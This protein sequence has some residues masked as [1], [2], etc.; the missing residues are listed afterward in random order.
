MTQ[1]ENERR[2]YRRVKTQVKVAI[3]KYDRNSKDV[4]DEEGTT[5][6]M[7]IG[8]LLVQHDKPLD[9][10]S[11]VI[12]SFGVPGVQEKLDFVGKV[13]RIEELSTGGYEVG[14]MF[15][16]VIFGDIKEFSRFVMTEMEKE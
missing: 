12:V 11:Y 9:V 3:Q 8:G 1:K 7:S 16:R 4:S 14:I 5:K 13:I 2:K 15:M 10:P 6:N